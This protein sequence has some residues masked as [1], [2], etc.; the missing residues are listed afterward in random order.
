MSSKNRGKTPSPSSP[1]DESLQ[2]HQSEVIIESEVI[3]KTLQNR[4]NY[5]T[6]ASGEIS[7]P[8]LPSMLD[9]SVRRLDILFEALG[10]KLTQ[11]KLEQLRQ[12]IASKIQDG[13]QIGRA[14]V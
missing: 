6:S 5:Y 13:F 4:F 11:D 2:T 10:H 7:M 1:A 9:Y 12:L 8:C 14:H 3:E